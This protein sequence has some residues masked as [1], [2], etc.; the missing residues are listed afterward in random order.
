[1]AEAVKLYEN[2][3]KRDI[4]TL[5]VLLGL[6]SVPSAFI[7]VDLLAELNKT[8]RDQTS[9]R[10]F[11]ECA[12]FIR[13]KALD[14]AGRHAEAWQQLVPVNRALFLAMQEELHASS[15]KQHAALMGLQRNRISAVG[16]HGDSGKR[17]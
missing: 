17:I 1:N 9:E 3:L 14:K 7:N 6:I 4:S 10:E 15:E 8:P 5:E 16:D 13:A 12:A 2:L 11:E